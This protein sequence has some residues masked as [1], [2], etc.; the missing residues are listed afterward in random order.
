MKCFWSW[1][2]ANT[3]ESQGLGAL[4]GV[5]VA[6]IGFGVTYSQLRSA[7]VTLQASNA[8]TIQKDG[9][10]LLDTIQENGFVRN[11]VDGKLKPEDQE[12]ARFDLWKMFNFYLS[13][14]RQSKAGGIG[15]EFRES[16]KRDFCGFVRLAQVD[17]EWKTML[18]DKSVSTEHTKMREDWCAKK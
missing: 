8:Y 18:A 17:T 1:L 7:N 11:L 12:K 15:D 5:L 2:K 13:V 16:Y 6:I 4:A 14:Y 10:E 3:D 9:R